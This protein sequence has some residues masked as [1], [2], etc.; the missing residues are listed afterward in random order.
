MI[1]FEYRVVY[2]HDTEG[3]IKTARGYTCAGTFKGAVDNLT[4]YYGEEQIDNIELQATV[5]N[6]VI[7]ISDDDYNPESDYAQWVGPAINADF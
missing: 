4:A 6:N 7:E 1:T 2:Y 5:M 3:K